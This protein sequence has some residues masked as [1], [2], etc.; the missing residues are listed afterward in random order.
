MVNVSCIH[1]TLCQHVELNNRIRKLTCKSH[2]F[3]HPHF[4]PYKAKNS[5]NCLLLTPTY[6]LQRH[7][8]HHAFQMWHTSRMVSVVGA[9]IYKQIDISVHV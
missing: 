9:Y 7:S 3:M 8:S 5:T 1:C 2:D 4:L 6:P